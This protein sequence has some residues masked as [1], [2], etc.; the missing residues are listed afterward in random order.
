M[1]IKRQPLL[2]FDSR[3]VMLFAAL[4]L[5]GTAAVHA[6]TAGQ[7]HPPGSAVPAEKSGSSRFTTGGTPSAGSGAGTGTTAT[8]SAV[9]VFERADTNRD[10]QLSPQEA[11]HV[12]AI[13][14]RF[15]ELDKDGNGLLSRS[16]FQKGAGS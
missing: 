1:Q 9:D 5:G 14:Q 8:T 13:A 16:E 11:T 12:P 2:S 3:S 15:K 4:T 6:Q 7:L 10:G